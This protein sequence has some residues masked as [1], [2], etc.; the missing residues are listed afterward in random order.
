MKR[1]RGFTLIEL[2]V[3]IAIIAVLIGM[4]LPAVQKV[5]EAA[6]RTAAVGTLRA[7]HA[8]EKSFFQQRGRFGTLEELARSSDLG[9]VLVEDAPGTAVKQGYVYA[10]ATG[11][12]PAGFLWAAV[13]APAGRASSG[14]SFYADETGPVREIA[15]PCP[16]GMSLV[17]V[18]GQWKCVSDAFGADPAK[19][20]GAFWSGAYVWS[21][22]SERSGLAW[23]SNWG[24]S[25]PAINWSGA[26]NW[27]AFANPN[28]VATE[29]SG[30]HESAAGFTYYHW[31]GGANAPAFG[32]PLGVAA[33]ETLDL[34][35]PGALAGAKDLLRN[36]DFLPAVQREF[37]VNGDG[38]LSLA[39]MLSVDQILAI[40]DRHG[41][42][43]TPEVAAIVRRL[44][45]G[46]QQ[47]FE[48]VAG[49]TALPAVQIACLEGTP[50]AFLE[51]ASQGAYASL[52]VL[53][54]DVSRLD[55]R[56]APAGD[57]TS[58]ELRV[59]ERRKA[60][61]LGLTEGTPPMLRFGQA[62]EL[63]ALLQ[64]VRDLVDGNPG[65]ADW[66]AGDAAVR[67]RARIDATL[68]LLGP[69]TRNRP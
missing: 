19:L 9:L 63:V 45:D 29:W 56:P 39:E 37:D 65:P 31:A 38:K 47:Q 67:L 12:S 48:P 64:K 24:G 40:A 54:D 52:D 50:G 15:P 62:D 41:A 13:A 6:N 49:E 59:N 8:A 14:G 33:V 4:L 7:M 17:L 69:R 11:A 28:T 43:V 57:M 34:L 60:T 18:E 66:V 46:L 2:L 5:R 16:P 3:V 36:P 53:R 26:L 44:V 25:L 61:L 23:Q 35:L 68:A 58:G 21:T 30:H 55:P 22:A 27:S 1:Q 42:A 20:R 51:L 32:N 10:V